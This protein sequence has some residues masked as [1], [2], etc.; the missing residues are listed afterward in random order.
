MVP[1]KESRSHPNSLDEPILRAFQ[2]YIS[3]F[4]T[5]K[6]LVCSNYSMIWSL[7]APC[8]CYEEGGRWGGE[9]GGH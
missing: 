5:L 1:C 4:R 8:I 2:D 7:K 6:T 3:Y 9:G